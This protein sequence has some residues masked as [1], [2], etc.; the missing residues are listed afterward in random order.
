MEKKNLYFLAGAAL[1][2]IGVI[3]M[4]MFDSMTK[5]TTAAGIVVY[6]GVFH[7]MTWSEQNT[8]RFYMLFVISI[9]LALVWRSDK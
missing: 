2:F 9:G 7:D 8:M 5:Q 4:M 3:F 6:T 1:I